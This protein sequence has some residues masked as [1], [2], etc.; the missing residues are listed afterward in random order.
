[1][2][3]SE[4]G[5]VKRCSKCDE[6]GH[7]YKHC[8]KDKEK[9]SAAEAGLLGSAADGARSTGEGTTST[10]PRPR[11]RRATSSYVVSFL[12]SMLACD[13]ACN[14][15]QTYRCVYV[16]SCNVRLRHVMSLGLVM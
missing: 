10:R 4:A 9:P 8:P 5:R 14:L 16:S 6:R 11:R 1:M 3:E 15:F 2:D 12:C 7:T 13:F